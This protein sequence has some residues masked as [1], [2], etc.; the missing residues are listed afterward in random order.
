MVIAGKKKQV[1][2]KPRLR[3]A[4]SVTALIGAFIGTSAV[5]VAA[6]E[7]APNEFVG[8]TVNDGVPT[9]NE[10]LSD[11]DCALVIQMTGS[12]DD[13]LGVY[14]VLNP[15]TST[16]QRTYSN[17]EA[18][19][20]VVLPGGCEQ[21]IEV[22]TTFT[23]PAWNP[24]SGTGGVVFLGGTTLNLNADIDASSA[25]FASDH[26]IGAGCDGGDGALGPVVSYF[27]GGAGG[28]G[29]I[30]GGGGSAG[31][32]GDPRGFSSNADFD[33]SPAFGG[34]ATEGGA[35]GQHG[36]GLGEAPNGGDAGCVGTGGTTD[37]TFVSGAFFATG[38]GAGGGGSYGAGGGACSSVSSGAYS[39]GGGGGGSYTG[40][41]SGGF[42]GT[43]TG[44]TDPEEPG[45]PGNAALEAEIT[46]AAHYLSLIHI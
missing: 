7:A 37:Q 29:I 44:F 14:E 24:E 36:D 31:H 3:A 41:G 39:S 5:P 45:F 12:V 16:P 28:G 6:Q 33:S 46:S 8:A 10:G 20:F 17:S 23:P 18:V 40:G 4:L 38:A 11:E 2:R 15:A 30:G 26:S 35:G 42:G 27:E 1:V 22:E 9:P 19:Q 32:V 21:A 25:G 13:G 34:T 43:N